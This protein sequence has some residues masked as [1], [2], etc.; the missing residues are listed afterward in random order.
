MPRNLVE[1]I[2]H[3]DYLRDRPIALL[4]EP[5]GAIFLFVNRFVGE[6]ALDKKP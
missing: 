6:R 1:V 2:A 3:P 5:L 4:Y